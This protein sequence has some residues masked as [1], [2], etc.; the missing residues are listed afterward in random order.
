MNRI[1][2]RVMPFAI[3]V[4]AV[5]AAVVGLLALANVFFPGLAAQAGLSF[6]TISD[7]L[8]AQASAVTALTGL[9]LLTDL[10]LFTAAYIFV[11]IILWIQAELRTYLANRGHFR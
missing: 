3:I 1:K 9:S 6:G 11:C 5:L 10:I 4:F 2:E 8:S 7:S